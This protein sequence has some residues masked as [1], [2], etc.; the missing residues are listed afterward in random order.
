MV[1]LQVLL[2]TSR[3]EYVFEWVPAHVGIPGNSAADE[4]AKAATEMDVVRNVVFHYY[5]VKALIRPYILQK[6][7]LEWSQ[8]PGR[9]PRLKEILGDWKSAYRDIRREEVVLARL[10]VGAVL[11]LVRHHFDPGLPPP[12]CPSC[13][14]RNTIYHLL[15]VCPEHNNHRVGILSYLG[16]HNLPININTLLHDDFPFQLLFDF[17]RKT[18]FYNKI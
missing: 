17:L 7:Q 13:N 6:W 12:I 10:R 9:L 4:A 11:Y 14:V 5:D 15:L 18:N 3:K 8:T 1:K 16:S 2:S